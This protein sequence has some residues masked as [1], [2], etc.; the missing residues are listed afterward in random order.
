MKTPP[1]RAGSFFMAFRK[2]LN[3][4]SFS[5]TIQHANYLRGNL[6]ANFL[7]AVLYLQQAS[8][9]FFIKITQ[10]IDGSEEI[11][12][13]KVLKIKYE[14]QHPSCQVFCKRG[15]LYLVEDY[16]KDLGEAKE[17]ED[18]F[19]SPKDACRM[20]FAQPFKALSVSVEELNEEGEIVVDEASVVVDENSPITILK[21]E[22]KQVLNVLDTFEHH[23]KKRDI[24]ALWLS[25]TDLENEIML[26][27]I[28]KEEQ[29]LFPVISGKVPMVEGYMAIVLEDH[30]EF[31]SLLHSFRCGLQVG[32]I[33]DGII[34]SVIV[35]LRSHILKENG[36]FFDM[37]EAGL[38]DEDKALVVGAYGQAGGKFHSYQGGEYKREDRVSASCKQEP[39]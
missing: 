22:H 39:S 28:M 26:H 34:H 37:L 20:G 16:F 15:E 14:C 12:M 3:F 8:G 27:S 7:T 18:I 23:L 36:E 38:S 1:L 10:K 35:N 30:K 5:S 29:G 31:L 4:L 17:G 6:R 2:I 21:N 33:H 25:A 9:Y 19:K 32:D 13:E 24:P 11:M